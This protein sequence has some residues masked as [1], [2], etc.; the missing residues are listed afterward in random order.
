MFIY[1]Y[2]KQSRFMPQKDISD[3]KFYMWDDYL[4]QYIFLQSMSFVCIALDFL[5]YQSL[6][7]YENCNV[8]LVICPCWIWTDHLYFLT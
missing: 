6:A 8:E 7:F 2:Q 3:L 5:P 4:N 1:F